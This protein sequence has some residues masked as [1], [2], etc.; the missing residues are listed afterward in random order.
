MSSGGGGGLGVAVCEFCVGLD[1]FCV[2]GVSAVQSGALY[3][4][5]ACRV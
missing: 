3:A 1:V 5:L 4:L 2:H